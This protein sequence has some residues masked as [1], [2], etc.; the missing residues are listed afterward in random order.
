MKAT[1]PK[2]RWQRV[3]LVGMGLVFLCVAFGCLGLYLWKEIDFV[4]VQGRASDARDF[5][6]TKKHD[7]WA[8][9]THLQDKIRSLLEPLFGKEHVR[10]RV[11][12]EMD[13][14]KKE[15]TQ[16]R[17]DPDEVVLRREEANRTIV[18]L[19]EGAMPSDR[20]V[21]SRSFE[22]T[23]VVDHSTVEQGRIKRLSVAVLIDKSTWISHKGGESSLTL[24][25]SDDGLREITRL[26]EGIVGYDAR[27]G[28]EV[29][30]SALGAFVTQGD[31]VASGV[32]LEREKRD[33][34]E[35][36]TL[37]AVFMIAIAVLGLVLLAVGIFLRQ[38]RVGPKRK[39]HTSDIDPNAAAHVIR[40]WLCEETVD[41][42]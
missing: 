25:Q 35:R 29:T 18:E 1:T 26:V 37:D 24:P 10:V 2:K 40:G 20:M 39:K 23:R 14:S 36:S 16:E 31:G 32:A 6:W 38:I 11:N 12:L 15:I 5:W 17:F 41:G 42:R 33:V 30:V 22:I 3:G 9:E 7:Q 34:S 19:P 28:D 4:G 13:F 8:M 27:R 21:Q